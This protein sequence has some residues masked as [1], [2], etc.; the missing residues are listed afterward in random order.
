[1]TLEI[2]SLGGKSVEYLIS[3]FINISKMNAMDKWN[4][5]AAGKHIHTCWLCYKYIDI[6]IDINRN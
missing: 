2:L 3:S 4:I 6:D 1:M 5:C